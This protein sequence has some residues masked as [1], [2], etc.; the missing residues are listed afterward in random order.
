M[1]KPHARTEEERK[2]SE[3]SFREMIEHAFE[4]MK[5]QIEK[6]A[7]ESP[8][9]TGKITHRFKRI[10]LDPEDATWISSLLYEECNRG[11]IEVE[12]RAKPGPY[13]IYWEFLLKIAA[14]VSL[15]VANRVISI[16]GRKVDNYLIEKAQKKRNTR[17]DGVY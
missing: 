12:I 6:T 5:K 8:Q 16:L 9:R 10:T 15:I 3:D 13:C 14:G 11:L 1:S 7:K 17:M 4:E 2:I